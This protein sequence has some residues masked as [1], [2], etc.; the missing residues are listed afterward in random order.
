MFNTIDVWLG[1]ELVTERTPNQAFRATVEILTG[2]GRDAA[3][4]WLQNELFFKDTAGEMDN[5]NPS[6]AATT[7]PVNEGLKRRFEYTK[8]SKRVAVRSRIHSDLFN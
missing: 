3:G 5:S 1:N 2:Y 4:S 8:E 6:P 7:A